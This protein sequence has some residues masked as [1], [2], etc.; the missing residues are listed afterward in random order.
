MK[1]FMKKGLSVRSDAFVTIEYSLLMPVLLCMYTF[2][3]YIGLFQ[4][5]R[6]LQQTNTFIL[7]IEKE[8]QVELGALK[9][10]EEQL[11]H[12]KYLLLDKLETTYCLKGTYGVLQ[13]NAVMA[14]PFACIGVGEENWVLQA[15]CRVNNLSPAEMIRLCKTAGELLKEF[16]KKEE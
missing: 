16:A 2:L 1:R 4:Y 14:N 7:G 9:Q 11:Y 6:C 10:K 13:S 12:E 5:N 3:V 15:E 8:E